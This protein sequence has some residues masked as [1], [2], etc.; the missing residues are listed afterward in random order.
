MEEKYVFILL[1]IILG[2]NIVAC[3]KLFEIYH[4]DNLQPL[5]SESSKVAGTRCWMVLNLIVVGEICKLITLQKM[6]V[7]FCAWILQLWWPFKFAIE[8]CVTVS[9][10]FML[11][12]AFC[13]NKKGGGGR[14]KRNMMQTESSKKKFPQWNYCGFLIQCLSWFVPNLIFHLQLCS[15]DCSSKRFNW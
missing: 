2:S 8:G 3:F 5:S 14:W 15:F 12:I 13:V 9:L 7:V 10:F 4:H 11:M 1:N 6:E